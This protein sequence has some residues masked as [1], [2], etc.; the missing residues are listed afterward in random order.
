MPSLRLDRAASVHLARPIARAL[1][2][3]QQSRIPILMYHGI[4]EG[5]D[6]RHPYYETTTEPKVFAQQMQFLYE[7]SYAALTLDTTVERLFQQRTDSGKYV[8]IT[9]DDGY[10]DFYTSAY[11]TLAELGFTATV[12]LVTEFVQKQRANGQSVEYLNWSEVR[13]LHA[14]GIQIGSHTVTHPELKFLD[15]SQIEEEVARS[16]RTI[17]DAIGDEV[18]SFSYPYAFPETNKEFVRSLAE[19]LGRQGYQNGVSTIIGTAGLGDHRFFLPRL[20]VNSWDDPR[21]FQAKLEGGYDWLHMPQYLVK[22][23]KGLHQTGRIDSNL[24]PIVNR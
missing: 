18:R 24:S 17:E 20:P 21:F 4:R 6:G 8:V 2:G 14:C 12:F 22:I 15:L 13:E 9:F 7:H 10:R 19:L 1:N 23:L 3:K 5:L 16:K 11:P